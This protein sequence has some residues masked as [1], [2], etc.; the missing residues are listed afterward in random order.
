MIRAALTLELHLYGDT[1]AL[2]AA[3]TTRQP[4][5]LLRRYDV[6]DDF[7]VPEA[8]FT[9]CS[10]WLAEALAMVGRGDEARALFESILGSHNGLGLYAE[11]ILVA[12]GSQAG[13]FPQTYSHVGLINTAFRLSR[14]WE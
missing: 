14:P 8:A 9:V 3:T 12:D 10:F 6:A 11:D 1:G 2:L 13:N 7:G 5:G 4:G